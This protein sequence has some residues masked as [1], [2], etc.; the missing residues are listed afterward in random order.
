MDLIDILIKI[1]DTETENFY[2]TDVA[3]QEVSSASSA[4]PNITE[5]VNFYWFLSITDSR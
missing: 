1:V 3:I 5:I 2:L 4:N